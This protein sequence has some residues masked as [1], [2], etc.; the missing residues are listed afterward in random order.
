MKKV[1][2]L[3]IFCF[4]LSLCNCSGQRNNIIDSLQKNPIKGFIDDS[5][6]IKLRSESDLVI[7]YS[8]Y[9]HTWDYPDHYSL[10]VLRNTKWA[11]VRYH[12]NMNTRIT[13]E[14]R[15]S[16]TSS[17]LREDL[18]DSVINIITA[19]KGWTLD[20]PKCEDRLCQI[21]DNGKTKIVD[22]KISDASSM[23]LI[24]MTKTSL[25]LT[26]FYAPEYLE[27]C[28]PG[29]QERIRFLKIVKAIENL[30]K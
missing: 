19:N 5:I 29:W 2:N 23:K 25:R 14:P 3:I 12:W 17:E 26:T 8:V 27:N 13:T 24:M 15:F 18:V 4:F 20:C 1:L 11:G 7:G 16:F 9:N 22:C 10:L 30:F 21:I 28:C 6:M